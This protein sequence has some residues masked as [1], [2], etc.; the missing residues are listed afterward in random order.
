MP[1]LE[2]VRLAIQKHTLIMPGDSV[3]VAVSGG[4]D[5]LALMHALHRLQ[6][7]LRCNL[8]VATVDHGWRG[9]EGA[10]DAVFVVEQARK[11]GL[12]VTA[13]R[14][15]MEPNSSGLEAAG[16]RA[17]YAYF[18]GVAATIGAGSVA[19][20]HHAD[21]QAE[22]VLMRL[23]RGAST[24]GLAGMGWQAHVPYHPDLKLIRPLLGVT[25]AEVEAYC[26]E[27][28]L[29][30]RHDPTNEDTS[31]LRNRIRQKTLPEL[32]NLN[33]GIKLA[34]VRLADLAAA[35][36]DYMQ[37]QAT[38]LVRQHSAQSNSQIL[39]PRNVFTGLHSAIQSR[40]LLHLA[41]KLY[42][43]DV[44]DLNYRHIVDARYVC[45]HGK[46][47]AIA[48]LVKGR[49]IRVEY[50]SLI[51]ES[52]TGKSAAPLSLAVQTP[53]QVVPEVP[54]KLAMGT[55]LLSQKLETGFT[56]PGVLHLPPAAELIIRSR[57]SG[58]RVSPP[59]MNGQSRTLKQWM[60]D[61]KIPAHQRPAVPVLDC[62]G[63]IAAVLHVEKG[64]V[65][66]P[67]HT[68]FSGSTRFLIGYKI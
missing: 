3:L 46:H 38:A 42:K 8:H 5:S 57:R 15:N 34:L 13:G 11:L 39:F 2:N 7:S 61:R 49:Q 52:V 41:E 48:R 18:A 22:T 50:D 60:I 44:P 17:R 35:D 66:H 20:A 26:E 40:L 63:R 21:D 14:L 12:A 31:F 43:P 37:Q 47:G 62:A 9:A 25:R 45:L 33:P 64:M 23:L 67:Y 55:V 29:Q 65:C 1:F 19:V 27:H 54:L 16:R 28:N 10:A 58:D 6:S 51:F 36:E 4:A 68:P 53:V 56:S 30:P 59:G 32:E 24:R